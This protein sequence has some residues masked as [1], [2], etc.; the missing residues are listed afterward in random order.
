M[1]TVKSILDKHQVEP[2]A[3]DLIEKAILLFRSMK[4][5]WIIKDAKITATSCSTRLLVE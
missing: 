5:E 4:I 3:N 1:R 2:H